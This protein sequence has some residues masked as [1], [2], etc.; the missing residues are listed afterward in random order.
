M[1]SIVP[2]CRHNLDLNEI[3]STLSNFI[4]LINLILVTAGVQHNVSIL[5]QPLLH[6]VRKLKFDGL[7]L[8]VFHSGMKIVE[9]NFG[10]SIM[11]IVD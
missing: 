8:N 9:H 7:I 4:H 2:M 6:I 1:C 11:N 10:H 5:K 3:Q